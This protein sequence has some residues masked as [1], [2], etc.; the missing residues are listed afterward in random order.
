MARDAELFKDEDIA[1]VFTETVCCI[2]AKLGFE[3]N[4]LNSGGFGNLF[5]LNLEAD[6]IRIIFQV[7]AI[8]IA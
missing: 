1:V 8:G 2:E 6:F 3:L 5:I 4:G 7:A